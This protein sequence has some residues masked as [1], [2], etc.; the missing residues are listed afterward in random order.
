MG[1]IDPVLTTNM[2][3]V[4]PVINVNAFQNMRG[5]IKASETQRIRPI[6]LRV[7]IFKRMV[8]EDRKDV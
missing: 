4:E 3:C 8:V 2:G 7:C 1:V 5:T 6:I